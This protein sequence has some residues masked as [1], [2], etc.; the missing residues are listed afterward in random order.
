MIAYTNGQQ[1]N[2]A[3]RD[4]LAE[5][6]FAGEGKEQV[7]GWLEGFVWKAEGGKDEPE[8]EIEA[9]ESDSNEDVAAE[10]DGEGTVS[11][12]EDEELAKKAGELDVSNDKA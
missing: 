9:K 10:Q 1:K 3:G 4:A 8:K 7:A 6:T 5:A 12:A 2:A 11:V